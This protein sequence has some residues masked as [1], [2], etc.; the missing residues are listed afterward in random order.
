MPEPFDQTVYRIA[1]D[2]VREQFGDDVADWFLARVE[3]RI[4]GGVRTAEPTSVQ[5]L[6]DDRLTIEWD[7]REPDLRRD[8]LDG[9]LISSTVFGDGA[10]IIV[11]VGGVR[12]AVPLTSPFRAMNPPG[13]LSRPSYP[14]AA[15]DP[16]SLASIDPLA[17]PS[18][19]ATPTR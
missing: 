4:E 10:I 12:L 18:P 2:L 11:E 7:N 9:K 15:Q 5:G 14:I 17:G 13:R 1:T 8:S 3:E 19:R 6:V 16:A